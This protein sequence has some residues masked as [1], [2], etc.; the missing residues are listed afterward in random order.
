MASTAMA[1]EAML[2]RLRAGGE[3][4]EPIYA[5]LT[6]QPGADSAALRAAL[7]RLL[8][9]SLCPADH[10]LA[11]WLLQQ[12]TVDLTAAGHGV[13]ETLYTLVAAVARYADPDDV[14]LLWRAREATPETRAGV[15]VE[16]FARAG[17]ER[18][19]RRLKALIRTGGQRAAEASEALQWLDDGLAAG[20]SSDLP[21]YFAWS[22]ER[23]G[24][25]VSGPT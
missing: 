16:Q 21:G 13:S 11:R 6:Y 15:D 3:A 24:L 9:G 25:H 22:D 5:A 17:V 20:A 12:E 18:V 1:P 4:A 7:T 14:L 23:F 8:A 2:A 19:R 10:D